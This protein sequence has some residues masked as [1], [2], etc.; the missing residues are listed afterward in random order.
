M[1]ELEPGDYW[2]PGTAVEVV[3]PRLVLRS[4]SPLDVPGSEAPAWYGSS[5]RRANVWAPPGLSSAEFLRGLAV[6]CDNRSTFAL[7][8]VLR[9]SGQAV[10]LG[11]AQLTSEGAMRP[12][13]LTTLVGQLEQA[14]LAPGYEMTTAMVWLGLN[15]LP[16]TH[17]SLRI[18]AENVRTVELVEHYGY[19]RFAEFNEGARLA[20]DYR[21][22]KEN[23]LT[24]H[25]QRCRGWAVRSPR[26]AG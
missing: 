7:L 1:S 24:R 9:S 2:T 8:A 19:Q 15:H 12:F 11:K 21:I 25:E 3:T 6:R 20:Y 13:V 18:Y 22:S 5:E 10:G 23:W 16:A 14:A 17:I 26:R 4:L